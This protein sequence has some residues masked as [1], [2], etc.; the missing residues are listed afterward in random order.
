VLLAL[1]ATS[2]PA[3][4]AASAA[5]APPGYVLA[6]SDEFDGEALDAEKWS[7]RTDSRL[8]STQLPANVSVSGG[9]LHLAVRKEHAG[10]MEYTGAGIISRRSFRHG[11]YQARCR[12][13]PGKGWHSSFWMMNHD[14]K[15]GTGSGITAQELDVCEND[16]I[17]PLSYGVNVH[18]WLPP[19]RAFG[20]KKIATPD[21]A[22]GFHVWGCEFLPTEV[23][24]L[25]DGQV[26]QTVDVAALEQSDQNIWLTT[27]AAPLGHTDAVDETRLPSEFVVDW[28]RFYRR[29]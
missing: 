21:L 16:S 8:W 6:W 25:F 22:A 15:G 3:A 19:H 28:V 4:E 1:L 23:R 10:G 27:I 7:Y 17:D 13:P 18:K 9:L 24:Y 29:E 12:M 5:A 11:F 26:V 20:G 2:A 14:G